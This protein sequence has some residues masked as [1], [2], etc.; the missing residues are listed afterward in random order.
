MKNELCKQK[1][2]VALF[3]NFG[4][5]NFG[6]DS[7]LQAI[8]H[9]LLEVLGNVEIN[10]ICT[11]PEV[12]HSDYGIFAVPSRAIA[13]KS[14]AFHNPL[15]RFAQK[16]IIRPISEVRRWL[17]G[18]QILWGIDALVV[19][20]TGL[21]TDAYTFLDW[22]P[23]DMF[24]WSV[25]AKLCR[26]KLLF[27]SVGAGPI[28]TRTGKFF[29]KT[30]LS[31]ADFRS[32]RDVS[33]LQYLRR[34]GFPTAGDRVYPDLAFSL[35]VSVRSVRSNTANVETLVVGIG[36]M[37]YAGKYSVERPASAVYSAYLE[38]LVTFVKWLV[39]HRYQVRLLIGDLADARV[40]REFRALLKQH[41]V[42]QDDNR[43]IDEPVQSV[44]QLL[45]QIEATDIVLATRFH[46]VLLS[47]LL[48]KPVIAVSFHHKCYS[49][50]NQ[51][52]LMRYSQDIN[53]LDADRLV[54]QFR[55]A[56]QNIDLLK[57]IIREK[58]AICRNALDEQY[59]IV[60][61]VVCSSDN[62]RRAAGEIRY[63][64]SSHA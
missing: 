52:G 60:S 12:V 56:Q 61:R 5:A 41:S 21:L 18:V 51:M 58:V 29:I 47:L 35:P 54:E 15:L 17:K 49:L 37:E 9:H 53:A 28:Y 25:T 24:R 45:A 14:R 32:Y 44:Q 48:N 42:A 59:G 27:V 16:A 1:Y 13:R 11:G 43:I 46:N 6:N 50:M 4:G 63:S 33:T 55:Q 20:G 62:R 23:Y 36:L 57:R 2:K 38:T 39:S 30:A 22:G 31:L 3:G 19:P 10:C 8:L 34:I 64:S 7:T 26:C 40:T